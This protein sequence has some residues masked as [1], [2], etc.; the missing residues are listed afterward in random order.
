MG[1]KKML[2]IITVIIVF[3]F[4]LMLATSYAWYSYE[5]ASTSFDVVTA[6]DE[7]EIVYQSGEYID[8][9][10]AIPIL[11]SDVDR[12]SDKYDFNIKVL[13]IVP[14]N[15]MVAKVGLI[16]IEISDELK[17]VDQL[18]GDSPFRVELF[19][20]GNMVGKSVSGKE[21]VS[22]SYEFGDVVLS[23][24]MDNQFEFR[25]YLL[26]N[27]GNQTNLMNQRFQAKIDVNVISRVSTKIKKVDGADIHISSIVID[28]KDSKY[29]PV[30]GYYDMKYVCKMG[31][32]LSWDTMTSSLHYQSGSYMGDSC[33]L[34]FT[35]SNNKYYIKDVSVGSYVNYVGNNGCV[36]TACHGENANYHNQFNQGYC[37]SEDNHFAMSGYR[38]LYVKDDTA[39]LVSAGSPECI[40]I[41]DNKASSKCDNSIDHVEDVFDSMNQLALKYCNSSYAYGGVCNSSSSWI[42]N[43][44]DI[45]QVLDNYSFS[46]CNGVKDSKC[47]LSNDLLDIG[48][49][50]WYY[51]G[52][53]HLMNYWNPV[54]RGFS[55]NKISNYGIRPVIRLDSNV[56]VVSGDGSLENPY[57]LGK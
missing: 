26:D 35:T 13:N 10:N 6:N 15:E 54:I 37:S 24:D 7:V 43:Y 20:Q 5:N 11:E 38:V 9:E 52:K 27:N 18:L 14:N 56:L 8:T 1:L 3:V 39:Y 31:S 21:L 34:N 30:D 28:G 23:N 12:Y 44:E 17:K 46:S 51:D 48:S 25:V 57:V 53:S 42:L 36:G 29:M 16:D 40:C 45:R 55:S 2:G 4:G 19:Y 41:H 50:Y 49:Y 47:G 32:N 33:D 22:S